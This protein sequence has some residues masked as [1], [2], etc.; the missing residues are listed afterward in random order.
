MRNTGVLGLIFLLLVAVAACGK[1][2][3]GPANA[4]QGVPTSPPKAT[5]SDHESS[6][7]EALQTA[8]TEAGTPKIDFD[9]RA[10]DFGEVETGQEVEKVFKFRNTGDGTLL[11]RN[12]RSG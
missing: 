10:F 8:N 2:E 11:I 1:G 5:A 4:T 9:Q 3:K 6:G 12:V 7:A